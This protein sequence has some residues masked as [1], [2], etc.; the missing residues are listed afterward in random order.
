MGDDIVKLSA[1]RQAHSRYLLQ[2]T[3]VCNAVITVM[4]VLSDGEWATGPVKRI[5]AEFR[6]M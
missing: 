6:Q 2:V 1:L 5:M 4:I 3:A